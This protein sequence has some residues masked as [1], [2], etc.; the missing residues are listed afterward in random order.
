MLT[1]VQLIFTHR[2]ITLTVENT[3]AKVH[4]L[5]EETTRDGLGTEN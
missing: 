1:W 2:L 4:A 3:A 5:G